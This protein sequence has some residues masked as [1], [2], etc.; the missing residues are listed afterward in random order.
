MDETST[1]DVTESMDSIPETTEA[2]AAEAPTETQ[3]DSWEI[4]GEELAPTYSEVFET[5]EETTVPISEELAPIQD[6]LLLQN[7]LL[8]ILICAVAL[9]AGIQLGSTLWRWLK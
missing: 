2:P 6:S 1:P 4:G 9:C 8:V 3:P 5:I 7:N